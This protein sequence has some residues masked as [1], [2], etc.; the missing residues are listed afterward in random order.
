MK[1]ARIQNIPP[2]EGMA[3]VI[4]LAVLVLLTVMVVGFLS[5]ATIDR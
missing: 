3:L 1:N 5:R 2:Q 4:V